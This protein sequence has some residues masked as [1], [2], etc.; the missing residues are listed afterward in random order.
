MLL[1][2]VSGSLRAESSNTCLLRAACEFLPRATT[3]SVSLNPGKL[4]LFS[5]DT[6]IDTDSALIAWI[7]EIRT[8]DGLVVSTPEYARGYPGALKNALDWLVGTDAFVDK[9]F[10]LLNASSRST[11]AQ[12]TLTTVLETMSGIHIVEA[13]TTVA[14]LGTG[15][16][17]EQIVAREDYSTQLRSALSLFAAAI[18]D[19]DS[20][21]A[22]D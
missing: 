8:A 7:E 17:V 13:S 2:G 20:G 16:T 5:P 14:L 9:P 19:R 10:M 3:M 4:P 22:R 15:L 12:K 18:A 1:L 11:V 21:G 6:P